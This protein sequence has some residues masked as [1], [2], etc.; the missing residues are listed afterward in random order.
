MLPPMERRRTAGAGRRRGQA[1]VELLAV[2]LLVLGGGVGAAHVLVRAWASGAAGAAAA[3]GARA[4]ALGADPVAAATAAL[5]AALRD[6]ATVRR[7]G[8]GVSVRVAVP[9]AG[10]AVEAWRR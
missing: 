4:A 5:P 6:G 3:T 7:R 8:A 2:A 1:T 9:A 10:G